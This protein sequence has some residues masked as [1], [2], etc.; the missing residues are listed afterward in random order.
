MAYN[1]YHYL[2]GSNTSN[3]YS[4]GSNYYSKFIYVIGFT[5]KE[6]QNE[7]KQEPTTGLVGK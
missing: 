3:Y 6:K 4:N 5:F 1:K 7:L 2:P